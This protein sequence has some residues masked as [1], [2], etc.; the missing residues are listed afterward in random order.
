MKEQLEKVHLKMYAKLYLAVLLIVIVS[1]LIGIHKIKIGPGSV[2]LLPM[3]Y[4]VIIGILIT[5]DVL[6][7]PLGFLKKNCYNERS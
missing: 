3:L 6:G 1:E 7:K 5:P 4:A 2:V